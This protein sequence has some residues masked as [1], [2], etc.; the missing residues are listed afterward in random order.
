MPGEEATSAVFGGA[1]ML[2]GSCM[3]GSVDYE[4]QPP[5]QH[6]VNCHCSRCR[7]ATGSAYAANAVVEAAAFRWTRGERQ[8]RRFDL[9]QARSF[10]IGFCGACGSPVP[11]VTRM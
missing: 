8:V 1:L 11:H 4:V 10:A 6:F 9:P 2:H 7:K 3:C 5:F